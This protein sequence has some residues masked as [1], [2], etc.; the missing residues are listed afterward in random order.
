MAWMNEI[1]ILSKKNGGKILAIK[2]FYMFTIL[3]FFVTSILKEVWY[4]NNI[5]DIP[6]SFHLLKHD[7]AKFIQKI[8]LIL[9]KIY[10]P[11]ISSTT[12][13]NQTVVLFCSCNFISNGKSNVQ[14][15]FYIV[16]L[17][18]L[19][20]GM[21]LNKNNIDF[22]NVVFTKLFFGLTGLFTTMSRITSLIITIHSKC[23]DFYRLCSIITWQ[24][25]GQEMLPNISNTLKLLC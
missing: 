7:K 15:L 13:L 21:W 18:Y 8:Y 1:N 25:L 6:W 19:K 5:L 3:S 10:L 11:I 24:P 17:H 16:K 20:R 23:N 2:R 9:S 22:G 14:Y 4:L 12:C